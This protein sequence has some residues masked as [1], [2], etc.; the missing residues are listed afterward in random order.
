MQKFSLADKLSPQYRQHM[1]FFRTHSFQFGYDNFNSPRKRGVT[2]EFQVYYHKCSR[3]S[4]SFREECFKLVGHLQDSYQGKIDLFYSGGADSE[5]ILRSFIEL[6][7]SFRPVLIRYNDGLNDHDLEFAE[8]LLETFK[9][10]PTYYD[11]NIYEFF[12]QKLA[13]A[14]ADIA[15]C[16]SPMMLPHFWA[17]EKSAKEG[18]FPVFGYGEPFF[19]R[20][21]GKSEWDSVDGEMDVSMLKFMNHKKIDGVGSFFQGSS[22]LMLSFLRDSFVRDQME[23]Q[24]TDHLDS[25]SFKL[26]FYKQHYEM[27]STPIET[28]HG[29]EKLI[30]LYFYY[31]PILQNRF[32]NAQYYIRKERLEEQLDPDGGHFEAPLGREWKG[33]QES[34]LFDSCELK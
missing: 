7:L 3:A 33:Y 13:F 28:Y 14:F 4:G 29:F 19:I 2:E 30:D 21:K 20:R 25:S 17:A 12:D 1:S 18:R 11:L 6:N 10:K 24:F 15:Q 16:C 9:L 5:V 8:T 31:F 23:N 26:E 27:Q 32:G 22:E 34:E